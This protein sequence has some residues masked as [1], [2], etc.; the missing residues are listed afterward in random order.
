MQ[1]E[2]GEKIRLG[3]I[4][5]SVGLKGEMKIYPYTDYKEKF[6]EIE[7][8][9]IDGLPYDI[10]RVRY[11]KSMVILKLVGINNR[12]EAESNREKEIFILRKDTPSL[13]EGTFYVK[14]LIGLRAV[15]MEGQPL[16]RLSDVIISESQDIYMIEPAEGG[17]AFPVPAVEEFVKE[18][19]LVN[20]IICIKL[21]EGLKE[22]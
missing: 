8:V 12:I 14:D 7:Y 21:I 17:K 10:E 4:V 16:G 2:D 20:G 11:A 3:K 18:I 15:D 5:N 13:P 9:I 22:L 19:D 6:E 1:K